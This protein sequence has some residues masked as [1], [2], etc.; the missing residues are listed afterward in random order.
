MGVIVSC[1]RETTIDS[2]V[3]RIDE[4]LEM[5]ID[6]CDALMPELSISPS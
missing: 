3:F 1:W 2:A 5:M 6:H 4:G